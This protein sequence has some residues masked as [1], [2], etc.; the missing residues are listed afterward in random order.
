[1]NLL[2]IASRIA[3]ITDPLIWSNKLD[4]NLID[5]INF[6]L[7]RIH[8]INAINDILQSYGLT[9]KSKIRGNVYSIG[10]LDLGSLL[11]RNAFLQI[12]RDFRGKI[13][14]R[15]NPRRLTMQ[16]KNLIRTTLEKKYGPFTERP[17][18]VLGRHWLTSPPVR[19]HHAFG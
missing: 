6:D 15:S 7:I 16:E 4:Q 19:P 11:L 14:F 1:M 10:Y 2:I 17:P 8:G 5:K 18:S 12:D 3:A 9:V 13:K